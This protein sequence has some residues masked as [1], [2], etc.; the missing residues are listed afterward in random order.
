MEGTKVYGCSDDL[1]EVDGDV[2]GEVGYFRAED[3]D[4]PALVMFN[5]G[6]ILAVKYGKPG[7]LAIWAISLVNR[8]SLFDRIDQCD[9]EDAKPYSDIAHFKPG[10]KRAWCATQW[11]V[12]E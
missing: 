6:T 11:Q 4:P 2:N 7:N 5:D 3:D 12:V 9:D 10:L 8:G 1:I